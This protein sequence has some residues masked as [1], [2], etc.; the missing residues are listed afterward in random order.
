M[1]NGRCRGCGVHSSDAGSEYGAG[2]YTVLT[3]TKYQKIILDVLECYK[4]DG[5]EA[6]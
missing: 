4:E 5:V 2:N 6:R 1:Q 3:S